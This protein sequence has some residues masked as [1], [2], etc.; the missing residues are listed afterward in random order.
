LKGKIN[1]KKN[2]ND[3]LKTFQNAKEKRNSETRKKA[4]IAAKRD[5]LGVWLQNLGK[6]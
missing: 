2:H 6:S 1:K 4:L 5:R 3:K